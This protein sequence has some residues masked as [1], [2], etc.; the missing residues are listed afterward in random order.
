[1]HIVALCK[2][3][4][5]GEWRRRNRRVQV[6]AGVK[7]SLKI[8][9]SNIWCSLPIVWNV[10]F[11]TWLA[12]QYEFGEI[13]C[14]YSVQAIVKLLSLAD[15]ADYRSINDCRS[16]RQL[17]IGVLQVC[18]YHRPISKILM[19]CPRQR[20]ENLTTKKFV[21]CPQTIWEKL[22]PASR[23]FLQLLDVL[24]PTHL[25]WGLCYLCSCVFPIQRYYN[26]SFFS[27]AWSVMC[28][29]A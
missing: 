14:C 28:L 11:F 3:Y 4:E 8:F 19:A 29:P 10:D 22:S 12:S 18:Q 26:D 27:G 2:K 1:M 13:L 16:T 23:E 20:W 21:V 15:E 25:L 24:Q 7:S 17:R 5:D 6:K 9:I